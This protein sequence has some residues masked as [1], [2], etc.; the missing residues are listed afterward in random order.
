MRSVLI[1]FTLMFQW[2]L[3][4]MN[5]AGG[6]RRALW[7]RCVAAPLLAPALLGGCAPSDKFT[8]INTTPGPVHAVVMMPTRIG[9]YG[10]GASPGGVGKVLWPD[11]VWRIGPQTPMLDRGMGHW[12]RGPVLLL[13]PEVP[14]AA[15]APAAFAVQNDRPDEPADMTITIAS[16]GAGAAL[17]VDARNE[18]G[19]TLKVSPVDLAR[20]DTL[21]EAVRGALRRLG[22]LEDSPRP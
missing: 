8:V 20:D 13:R 17:R 19:G 3:L 5:P 21:A 16:A 12:G 7:L 22:W 15:A 4:A 18:K 2:P 1:F 11:E 14:A 6:G 9:G 10:V